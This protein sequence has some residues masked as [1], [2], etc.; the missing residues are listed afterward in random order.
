MTT[1]GKNLTRYRRA[2]GLTQEALAEALGVSRQ[3]VG[4]WEAGAAYPEAEKLPPLADM[5]HCS[6]D[7]LL[8]GAE[9]PESAAEP[10]DGAREE[11]ARAEETAAPEER[12]ADPAAAAARFCESAEGR[13][14]FENYDAHK[15]R[16]ALKIAVGVALILTG[17]SALLLL[18]TRSEGIGVFALLSF[19]AAAVVLFITAG[20]AESAF[21]RTFPAVPDLYGAEEM[22]RFQKLFGPG[23]AVGVVVI[24]LAVALL[25]LGEDRLG[26][27]AAAAAFLMAVAGGVSV[28]V[29]LG[30]QHGKYF[31][32]RRQWGLILPDED[33]MDEG[34][35]AAIEEQVDRELGRAMRQERTA[36]AGPDWDGAIMLAATG[37]F[38][39][40]GFLFSAWAVAWVIFPLS[41]ILCGIAECLGRKKQKEEAQ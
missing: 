27:N 20:T 15:N 7:A 41:G 29:Y 5:L 22:A 28:L 14:A 9:E 19:I 11:N 6:L 30:I 4:K 21:W 36:A 39:L 8:R 38:L 35:A 17:V 37:I 40:A 12:A 31:P 25:V 23:I 16:F 10:E 32:E 13:L 2:A 24:L 3:A 18:E 34:I 26:E 33:D 1:F